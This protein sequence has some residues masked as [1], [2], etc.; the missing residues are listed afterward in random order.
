MEK[1]SPSLGLSREELPPE[2]YSGQ[3]KSIYVCFSPE[4][5]A[6]V[7]VGGGGRVPEEAVSSAMES[8]LSER[9]QFEVVRLNVTICLAN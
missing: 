2:N 9:V 3:V 6:E 7:P 8:T 1:A 5:D 4:P